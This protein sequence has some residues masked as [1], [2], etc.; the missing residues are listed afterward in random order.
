MKNNAREKSHINDETYEEYMNRKLSESVQYKP[1]EELS[2]YHDYEVE[3][4]MIMDV[5]K[6]PKKKISAETKAIIIHLSIFA[7]IWFLIY[8]NDITLE[9]KSLKCLLMICSWTVVI[10]TNKIT[11]YLEGK[12]KD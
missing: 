6:K 2:K 8:V 7:V 1:K 9:S 10:F 12:L 5:E 11:K 4:S 3:K